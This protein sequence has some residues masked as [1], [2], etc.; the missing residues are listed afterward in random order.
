M[1]SPLPKV[2]NCYGSKQSRIVIVAYVLL[3]IGE[4]GGLHSILMLSR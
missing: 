2:V 3:V 4:I 1:Q